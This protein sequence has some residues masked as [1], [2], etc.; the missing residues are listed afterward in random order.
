LR[1]KNSLPLYLK[2]LIQE[3]PRIVSG[4]KNFLQHH[5][6]IFDTIKTIKEYF[7]IKN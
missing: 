5:I 7:K 1:K 3:N 6:R 2:K 4:R